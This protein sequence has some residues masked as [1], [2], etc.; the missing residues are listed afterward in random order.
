MSQETRRDSETTREI[1][2]QMLAFLRFHLRVR[3]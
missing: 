1:I 2:R 3:E